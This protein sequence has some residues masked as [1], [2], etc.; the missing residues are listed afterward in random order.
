MIAVERDDGLDGAFAEG[1][2]V[3]DDDRAAV[4]LQGAGDDLGGGGAEAA[5]EHDERA[6][7]GDLVVAVLAD[8]HAAF[9]IAGLHDRAGGDEQAGEVDGFLERAAA[10]AAEVEDDAGDVFLLQL[11]DEAGDIG[12]GGGRGALA[13]ALAGVECRADR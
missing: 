7:V 12:G 5:G 11:G 8:F 10:V 6:V 1:G 13:V 3:A 4:V 9:E 2:G